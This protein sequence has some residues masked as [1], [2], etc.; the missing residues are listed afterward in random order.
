MIPNSF[1]VLKVFNK[2][3]TQYNDLSEESYEILNYKKVTKNKQNKTKQLYSNILVRAMRP[4][5]VT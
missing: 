1:S 4:L 2:M 5:V 3:Y